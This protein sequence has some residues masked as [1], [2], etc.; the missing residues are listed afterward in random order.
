MRTI[1]TVNESNKFQSESNRKRKSFILSMLSIRISI[2]AITFSVPLINWPAPSACFDIHYNV[3]YMKSKVHS[4]Y[5][6]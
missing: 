1:A 6:F 5:L 3:S 2:K 4:A